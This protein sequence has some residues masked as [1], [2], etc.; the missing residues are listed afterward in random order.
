MTRR[1]KA[2]NEPYFALLAKR[3]EADQ[4]IKKLDGQL[5]KMEHGPRREYEK[6]SEQQEELRK[7]RDELDYED[8][9]SWQRH[10]SFQEGCD[11]AFCLAQWA[12]AGR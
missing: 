4:Q 8:E 7:R 11:M 9:L 6:L 5:E 10:I 1:V 12:P 2:F 3:K